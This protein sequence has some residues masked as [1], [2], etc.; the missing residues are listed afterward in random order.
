MKLV[1]YGPPGKEKPGLIDADGKL[2]DLSRK[3]K[4]IDGAALAP[5]KLKELAK[6]DP[7]KLPL[8]KGRPRLG[9][10]V[11]TPSKFVAIGLN[12][13]DHARETGSPI[14]EH[15]IVFFKSQTCIVGPN[16]NVMVPRDSTQLDWEVELGVVIGRTARY[17]EEKDALRYVAGYCV[18]NDVSERDFQLRKG[19]S[20][21]SKG[22]GCDT[23]GPL[24][25]WLVTRDEVKDPQN[26]AMWLDVNGERRQRGNTNTMIFGVAALVAD[27]SRYMTLLPGDVITT[28]TPPGVGMGMKPQTWLKAGDVITLG[29]DGLGEQRQKVVPFKGRR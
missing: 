3:V 10:C 16:D 28:G 6:L 19:A 5:A 29:I 21:W 1:R 22:K 24:G 13:S 8:V 27:V 9:P 7:K 4:D 2:R 20:Q 23:F 25:P 12:F 15:P 18:I 14:P 26:L 11:A 17:V